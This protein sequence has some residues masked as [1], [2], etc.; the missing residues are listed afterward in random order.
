MKT[1]NA[2][3][4]PAETENGT[5]GEPEFHV[6]LSHNSQDK[7]IVR[8]PAKSLRERGLRV[9]LQADFPPRTA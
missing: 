3:P 4:P 8:L 5:A 1:G 9:W 6:F 7:P 2:Q